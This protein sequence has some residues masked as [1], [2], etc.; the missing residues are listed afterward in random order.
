MA[1]TT[2]L[3]Q[4]LQMHRA[5]TRRMLAP[6][7]RDAGSRP[8]AGLGE[9]GGLKYGPILR[10]MR[11]LNP[12]RLGSLRPGAVNNIGRQIP[13]K[14]AN[15]AALL[16]IRTAASQPSIWS[17]VEQVFPGTATESVHETVAA[18][19]G[20]MRRGTVI[21]KMSITPQ[22]GQSIA[23]FKSQVESRG[24]TRPT[25]PARKPPKPGDPGVRRFS[26]I[27]E[28]RDTKPPESTS[29][30]SAPP[31]PPAAPPTVQRQPEDAEPPRSSVPS[32]AESA[33]GP[34]SP[35]PSKLQ[36]ATP[37]QAQSTPVDGQP[38]SSAPP[39]VPERPLRALLSRQVPSRPVAPRAAPRP[40]AARTGPILPSALPGEGP[41]PIS[42]QRPDAPAPSPGQQQTPTSP[43]LPA[44]AVPPIVP[45]DVA[46]SQALRQPRPRL[47]V[48]RPAPP[49]AQDA[50][51][52]AA[53]L[54]LAHPAAPATVIQRQTDQQQS[55][56]GEQIPPAP[57]ALTSPVGAPPT[58]VLSGPPAQRDDRS[59]QSTPLVMHLAQ[60]RAAPQAVRFVH[61]ERVKSGLGQPARPLMTPRAGQTLVA[62]PVAPEALPD[63]MPSAPQPADMAARLRQPAPGQPSLPTLSAAVAPLM[64]PPQRG[65]RAAT[66]APVDM[67]VARAPLA[68]PPSS[69]SASSP[70]SA[71][72]AL[73]AA[74]ASFLPSPPVSSTPPPPVTLPERAPEPAQLLK[75]PA[76]TQGAGNVVQRV[77]EEHQEG[78]GGSRGGASRGNGSESGQNDQSLDLDKLAE[79]VFPL[80]KRLIDIES[81]RARGYS[82]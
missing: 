81:E 3:F 15:P 80:V 79:D 78:T 33:S 60:R 30:D 59:P 42:A 35:P 56:A 36:R 31:A 61:P 5:N 26:R 17:E 32:P 16:R 37:P 22:P 43:S 62:R 46:Q 75:P 58:A 70:V 47:Q 77:W 63:S 73:P 41:A 66:A 39:V 57:P 45:M 48:A 27:E 51:K 50:E 20:T 82:R 52:P 68:Q 14:F 10:A 53:R 64:T 44:P 49:V 74:L 25:T 23:A 65:I 40:P 2:P 13:E 21:Q 12:Q 38:S 6:G 1:E 72:P 28:I 29:G 55:A 54:P 11:A 7:L 69:V 4:R 34:L 8:L 67:P 76:V 24:L 18:E 71:A 19:P 9:F